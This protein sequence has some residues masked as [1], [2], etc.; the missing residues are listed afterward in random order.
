MAARK[1]SPSALSRQYLEDEGYVVDVVER[2]IPGACIRKDLFGF[3]DLLALRG[4]NLCPIIIQTTSFSNSRARVKKILASPHIGL[5]LKFFDVFV[6][7]WSP[8]GT[9]RTVNIR[10]LSGIS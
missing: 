5:V 1:K 2:F 6:H 3:G 7:G 10:D 9:L 8:D 4:T